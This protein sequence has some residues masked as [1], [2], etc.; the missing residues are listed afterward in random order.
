MTRGDL[1]TAKGFLTRS[2][3]IDETLGRKEGMAATLANLGF[4]ALARGDTETGRERLLK[5]KALY[6]EIDAL[7]GEGGQIVVQTLEELDTES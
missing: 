3:K 4:L 6:S 1:Y 5:A 7:A 2:L